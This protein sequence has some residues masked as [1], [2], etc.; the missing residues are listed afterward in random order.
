MGKNTLLFFYVSEY[1]QG[2]KIVEEHT[3]LQNVYSKFQ[4]KSASGKIF[5]WIILVTTNIFCVYNCL[6]TQHESTNP[7][8]PI[9]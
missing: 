9:I 4:D 2:Y 8:N 7:C 3:F 6:L 1:I 5:N